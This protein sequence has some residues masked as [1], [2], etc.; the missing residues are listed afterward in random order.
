MRRRGFTIVELLIVIVVIAILAAITIVAYNGIQNRAKQS[1]AQSRLTQANKKILSF[2]ATHSDVYPEDLT[3]AEVDNS[4]NS[5]QYS[6]NN[7]PPRTYGLTITTGTFS[8][9]VTN[10]SSSP[11]A[12]GYQGHGQG[13]VAA[14]TNLVTNPSFEV[15]STGWGGNGTASV[16]STNEQ[17]Y[18]G[19]RSLKVTTTGTTNAGTYYGTPSN[20]VAGQTYTLSAYVYYPLSFGVGMRACAWGSAVSTLICGNYVATTG[21]WQRATVTFTA[22][23]TATATL[24]IYNSGTHPATGSVAYIDGVMLNSGN[25]YAYADGTTSNWVWNGTAHNATSTGPGL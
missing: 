20:L 9:F 25:Q 1:A 2:A 23:T 16:T 12:G 5:L 8:Y 24:Y 4:D 13:G 7:T 18:S 6:V 22:Q 15:N 11:V 21:S 17:A 14:I 19:T 10:A 3:E